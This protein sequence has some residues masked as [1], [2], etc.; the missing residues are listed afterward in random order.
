M[1][2]CVVIA[3]HPVYMR[4]NDLCPDFC[5]RKAAIVRKATV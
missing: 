2:P 5:G 3:Q 4:N 1:P